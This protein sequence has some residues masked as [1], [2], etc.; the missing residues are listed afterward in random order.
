[1]I[2]S[3]DGC[4]QIAAVLLHI[5]WDENRAVCAP[6]ARVLAQEEGIVPDPLPDD[7]NDVLEENRNPN[8]R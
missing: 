3:E 6:H 2:C 5:P 7:V 4:D 1:M 8:D